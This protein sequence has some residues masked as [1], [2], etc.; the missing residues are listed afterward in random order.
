[1]CSCATD[2][3]DI[4]FCIKAVAFPNKKN[5]RIDQVLHLSGEN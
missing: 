3:L 1:M 5:G 4:I 2:N